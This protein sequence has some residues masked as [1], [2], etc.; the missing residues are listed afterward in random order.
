M[1]D[2]VDEWVSQHWL[3]ATLVFNDCGLVTGWLRLTAGLDDCSWLRL[4][5]VFSINCAT[6][7]WLLEGGCVWCCAW[8]LRWTTTC[9]AWLL[10]WTTVLINYAWWLYWMT[11]LD[12]L[13]NYV[14][15]LWRL[16]CWMTRDSENNENNAETAERNH[17]TEATFFRSI[18][19]AR[20]AANSKG[21]R[22]F[23]ADCSS[24]SSNWK[25]RCHQC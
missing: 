7:V 15:C 3:G 21:F 1:D 13:E 25:K 22:V 11:M 2:C 20:D 5:A 6:I 24:V 14:C 17:T 16:R 10:C 8:R 9:N 18:K 19:R 23:A 12:R 4:M